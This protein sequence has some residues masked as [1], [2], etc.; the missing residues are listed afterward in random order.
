MLP[1]ASSIGMLVMSG[2]VSD[3]YVGY[4]WFFEEHI[5][6]MLSKGYSWQ[7]FGNQK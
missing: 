4:P 2:I 1:S 3:R 7:G 6:D 5:E